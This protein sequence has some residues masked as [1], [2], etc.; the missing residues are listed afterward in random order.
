MS[1]AS[2]HPVFCARRKDLDC[3][4][5]HPSSRWDAMRADRAGWFHSYQEEQAYC[6]AHVPS[7]VPAWRAKQEARLHKVGKTF[8]KLPTV[9]K[10]DGC[11]LH[12]TEESEDPEALAEIRDLAYLHA[13]KT[14][15]R[16]TVTTT[17]ELTVEPVGD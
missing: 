1:F 8:T 6:P 13:R 10:C 14:G 3:Q 9:V 12:R 4:A 11:A 7:W 17:A 16:V 15:H 2:E 5:S